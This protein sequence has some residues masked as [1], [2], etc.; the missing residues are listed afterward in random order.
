VYTQITLIILLN[1]DVQLSLRCNY[2]WV[3]KSPVDSL[4]LS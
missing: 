4:K 2:L 1:P 3:Q